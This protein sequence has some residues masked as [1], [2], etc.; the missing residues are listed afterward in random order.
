MGRGTGGNYSGLVN[1]KNRRKPGLTGEEDPGLGE[2]VKEKMVGG[3][4]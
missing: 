1:A 3:E 4:R 2:Y